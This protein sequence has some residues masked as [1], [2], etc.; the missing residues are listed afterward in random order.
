MSTTPQ[1]SE[2]ETP[3]K[4]LGSGEM[5]DRIADR[6][7]TL[8]RV[9]SMG[10]DQAWRRRTVDSLLAKEGARVLDLATGTGDLAIMIAERCPG[11][12]VVGVD[13]SVNMLEV[14]KKK[15]LSKE[16]ASRIEL[17]EG[18]AEALEFADNNFDAVSIAFGIRNVPDRL[19]GLKEILRVTRPGGRVA[20][21]E[22]NE[23]Q[24]GV[25]SPFARFHIRHVVPRLG[26]MLSGSQEY[27]YLQES[28]KAFP[29]P[30]RFAELMA[31][32]GFQDVEVT[33]LTFG[34]CCLYVGKVPDGGAQL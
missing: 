1:I 7:D 24:R 16:L 20:V 6:Y 12:N 4:C 30:E 34:V 17:L 3:Q 25:L 15:V 14:G 18:D 10:I 28:I 29:A 2:N 19:Q 26:A 11:V 33:E 31:E 8:N 13:P 32:A 5:F 27:R 21:L 23:P 9:I 22:L